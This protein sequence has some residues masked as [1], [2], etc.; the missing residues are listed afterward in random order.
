MASAFIVLSLEVLNLVLTAPSQTSNSIDAWVF[1]VAR[2]PFPVKWHVSDENREFWVEVIEKVVLNISDQQ[3]LTGTAVLIA[4]FWTHCSISVYHFALASDLAWFSATA[5]LITL[6]LLAGFL[7]RRPV[8]RNWRVFMIACLAVMLATSSVMQGHQDWYES[9]AYSA[10]CSFDDLYGNIAGSPAFWMGFNLVLIGYSYPLSIIMLYKKPR[11]AL[12]YWLYKKPRTLLKHRITQ[13]KNRRAQHFRDGSIS[14]QL[15]RAI[16]SIP[17]AI[18]VATR[19]LHRGLAV[20]DSSKLIGLGADVVWFAYGFYSLYDDRSLP[21]SEMEGTE[22]EMSFGQIM[23]ILLLSSTVFV[24]R[25]AYDG[26]HCSM[27]I[28][29][30][31]MTY[32]TDAVIARYRLSTGDVSSLSSVN[33]SGKAESKTQESYE[34]SGALDD[35]IDETGSLQAPPQRMDTEMGG[36]LE[37]SGRDIGSIGTEPQRRNTLPPS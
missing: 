22:N 5:H 6:P 7:E 23:P 37:A 9:W 26:K 8:L 17:L 14:A 27:I 1:K 20:I 11:T 12:A 30:S 28:A 4:S 24:F 35:S 3:L 36:R 13:L 32:K 34:M 33:D 16:L 19:I 25:E 10:Q 18:L 31:L 2:R 29:R 15:M 21:T